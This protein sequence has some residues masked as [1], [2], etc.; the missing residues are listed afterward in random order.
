VLDVRYQLTPGRTAGNGAWF[1]T[2]YAPVLKG[3]VFLGRARWQVDLPTGWVPLYQG[4]DFAA[5]Q[6]WEWVGGLL[7]PH[8]SVAGG[9]LDHWLTGAPQQ[10]GPAEAG[11]FCWRTNLEPVRIV[12]VPRQAWLIGSSL[13]FLVLGLF[14]AFAPLSRT[15]FWAAVT[16]LGLAVAYLGIFWPSVM[17]AA[18]YGVEPGLA[19]LVVVLTVHWLLQAHYQRQ[20]A[21]L[22]AFT[23][24]KPG[25][26]VERGTQTGTHSAWP[27]EP[28]TVD[29][30]LR[31]DS[32]NSQNEGRESSVRR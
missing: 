25:S 3:D 17:P 13:L 20:V 14:L 9:E 22:P 2:F 28:S 24:L 32:K 27:K 29:A 5:E 30:Q 23:R 18:L 19:V 16:V 11:L 10:A 12:Q 31:V 8:A 4:G 7:T 1:S 21:F 15:L 6:R 26:I